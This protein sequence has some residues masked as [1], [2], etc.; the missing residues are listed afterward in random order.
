MYF[1]LEKSKGLLLGHACALVRNQAHR[2]F[3]SRKMRTYCMYC[4]KHLLICSFSYR[5]TLFLWTSDL[6]LMGVV[7]RTTPSTTTLRSLLRPS[8]LPTERCV[9]L[10]RIISL[11]CV[12]VDSVHARVPL[13]CTVHAILNHLLLCV[14]LYVAICAE[15]AVVFL[16]LVFCRLERPLLLG[17]RW[18]RSWPT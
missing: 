9:K 15:L 1:K 6:Q 12:H 17:L 11:V 4:E 14:L 10:C 7:F 3:Y 5:V 13:F 8:T 2:L 16:A 18:R